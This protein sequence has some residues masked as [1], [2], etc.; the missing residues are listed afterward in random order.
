MHPS[1]VQ[2]FGGNFVVKLWKN[3][4]KM[5]KRLAVAQSNAKF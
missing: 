4:P 1:K 2:F 3:T 5:A